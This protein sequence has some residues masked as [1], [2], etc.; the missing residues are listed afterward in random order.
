MDHWICK[1][2]KH[3][4]LCVEIGHQQPIVYCPKDSYKPKTNDDAPEEY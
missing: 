1:T 4:E 2:C 3:W